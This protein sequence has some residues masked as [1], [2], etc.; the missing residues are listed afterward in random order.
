MEITSVLIDTGDPCPGCGAEATVFLRV[1]DDGSDWI[2]EA[3]T[4]SHG[5]DELA[6]A[7]QA[8]VPAGTRRR[9][10]VA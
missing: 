1:V 9:R 7:I 3:R 8:G 5:C 2:E 10:R 4:C 6:A